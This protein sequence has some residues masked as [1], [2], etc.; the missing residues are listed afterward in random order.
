M[1]LQADP[2]VQYAIQQ[3]VGTRKTRLLLSDYEIDSPYNTYRIPGLPPGPVGLPGRG[4]LEAVANPADVP[5]L[6]FVA[7]DSGRH[8]FTRTYAEHLRAI[9]MVR[10]GR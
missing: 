10:G 1:P 3:R 6:F 5:Y 9:R 8:I 2:T 7:A 4:A